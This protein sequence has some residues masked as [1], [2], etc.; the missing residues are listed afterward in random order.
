[1]GVGES[2]RGAWVDFFAKTE[3]L[4]AAQEGDA[5]RVALRLT[6][7]L[8]FEDIKAFAEVTEQLLEDWA[9]TWAH[10]PDSL[11]AQY[12]R[13]NILGDAEDIAAAIEK[14]NRATTT[15]TSSMKDLASATLLANQ[16]LGAWAE[17]FKVEHGGRDPLQ[18]YERHEQPLVAAMVDK[19]WGEDFATKTG[20]P[21]NDAEWRAHWYEQWAPLEAWQGGPIG[22]ATGPMAERAKAILKALGIEDLGDIYKKDWDKR[23]GL[24]AEMDVELT[25]IEE[26]NLALGNLAA[27]INDITTPT[28]PPDGENGNGA[29][30]AI[31]KEVGK[32]ISK[33][34]GGVQE[35]QGGGIT[36]TGGLAMLHANEAILPLGDPSRAAAIFAQVL[37]RGF[38]MPGGGGGVNIGSL[39]I[40]VTVSGAGAASPGAIQGAVVGAI[41]GRAGTE[42]RR[43][44]RRLGQ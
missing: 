6:R 11:A 5:E 42:L 43:A 22:E 38:R 32:A 26:L 33:T 13:A 1:A 30:E 14:A 36:A 37:N 23:K 9:K 44:A 31:G 10:D 25:K 7:F 16:N 17:A 40:P 27:Y 21:P 20:R 28:K 15:S 2:M 8:P 34:I 4:V 35:F 29:A 12:A 39:S 41:R 3:Q 24:I 18:V 19:L